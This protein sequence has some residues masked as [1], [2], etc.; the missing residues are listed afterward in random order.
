M[1]VKHHVHFSKEPVLIWLTGL[2]GAGKT[3]LALHLERYLSAL[4]FKVIVLDG[5]KVR[6]GLNK[7]LGFSKEDRA[8]NLRRIGEVAKILLDAHIIVIGAFISPYREDR[9]LVKQI[10]GTNRYIEIYV[11]CAIDVCEKRDPKGLYKKARKGAIPLFT[12]LNSPYEAPL[13]PDIEVKT[14]NETVEQS[15]LKIIENLK[16][17]LD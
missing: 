16:P 9:E 11:N 8:E 17:S 14:H 3:T 6:Q 10:V 2:S 15:L 13:C 5:D 7:D 12:G 4:G 1:P